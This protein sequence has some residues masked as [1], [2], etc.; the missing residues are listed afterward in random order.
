MK[1]EIFLIMIILISRLKIIWA[2]D[3]YLWIFFFSLYYICVRHCVAWI[4]YHRV[5][6]IEQNLNC[7]MQI[8][9]RIMLKKKTKQTIKIASSSDYGVQALSSCDWVWKCASYD[10][11]VCVW[12][13]HEIVSC[14]MDVFILRRRSLLVKWFRVYQ[15]KTSHYG[16]EIAVQSSF[17]SF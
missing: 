11:I 12:L 13:R 15:S 9:D 1:Y 16:T 3:F 14:V 7:F 2:L 5:N 4:T 8:I 6:I 17:T 10:L